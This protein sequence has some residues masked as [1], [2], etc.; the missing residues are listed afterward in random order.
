[1][2]E[3]QGASAE[4][5]VLEERI[6]GPQPKGKPLAPQPSPDMYNEHVGFQLRDNES[7]LMPYSYRRSRRGTSPRGRLCA[8]QTPTPSRPHSVSVR[9]RGSSRPCFTIRRKISRRRGALSISHTPASPTALS[10]TDA[11][12]Q[13]SIADTPRARAMG[14]LAHVGHIL[15]PTLLNFGTKF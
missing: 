9:L 2:V 4:E 6:E 3:R 11:E 7:P 5:S 1:M 10:K 12:S 8:R 14:V 13:T 15:F